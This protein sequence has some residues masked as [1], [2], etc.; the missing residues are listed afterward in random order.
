M[1]AWAVFLSILLGV[2]TAAFYL[3]VLGLSSSKHWGAGQHFYMLNL[4][5]PGI[6]ILFL[7]YSVLHAVSLFGAIFGGKQVILSKRG[8]AFFIALGVA[9]SSKYA[10]VEDH[11]RWGNVKLSDAVHG[12]QFLCHDRFYS[13]SL[14][15]SGYGGEDEV[16]P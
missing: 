4:R 9:I 11:H 1:S 5:Q 7:V 8:F 13:I 14:Q 16:L 2:Y 15:R 12:L 3:A 10:T 6:D